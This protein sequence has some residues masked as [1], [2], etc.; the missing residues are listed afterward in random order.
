M[1]WRLL[2]LMVCVRQQEMANMAATIRLQEEERAKLTFGALRPIGAKEQGI[3]VAPSP[4]C[5]RH[6]WMT[7]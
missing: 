4:E 2:L 7:T 6:S 1:R 3:P 5:A